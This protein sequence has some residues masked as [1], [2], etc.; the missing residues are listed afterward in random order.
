M[1]HKIRCDEE[2]WKLFDFQGELNK[3][4]IYDLYLTISH[5]LFH[6]EL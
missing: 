4:H 5:T 1:C 3:A 2:S 6:S